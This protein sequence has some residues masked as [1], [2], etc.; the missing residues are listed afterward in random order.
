MV[1]R[2]WTAGAQLL[3]VAC[4]LLGLT[5]C[6]AQ[7]AMMKGKRLENQGDMAGAYEAYSKAYDSKPDHEEAEAGVERTRARVVSDSLEQARQ[8]L[9]AADYE[10]SVEA[11]AYAERFDND[12]P[13][14]YQ[15][16]SEVEASL[17]D[18]LIRNWESGDARATYALAVRG[19]KLF[20]K[21]EYVSATFEQVRMH[22]TTAAE[23]MLRQ[24]KFDVSL[25]AVRTITE[26]EPERTAEM[27]PLEKRILEA[28]ADDVVGEAAGHLRR[29][30]I[31]AAAA[32]YA[33][34]YELAGRQGDLDKAHELSAKLG[35]QAKLTLRLDVSGLAW[36][37]EQLGAQLSAG[38]GGIADVSVVA[39]PAR[40][41][42]R[43]TAPAPKCTE[44]D[45]V[46]P[47]SKEYVS[48]QVEKPNPDFVALAEDL[49]RGMA[50]EKAAKGEGDRL[51]PELKAAEGTLSRYDAAVDVAE[52]AHGEAEAAYDQA[53]NQLK[54]AKSKRDE[55]DAQIAAAE[56]AGTD[57]ATL[58][59]MDSELGQLGLRVSEWSGEVIKREEAE[60]RAR[61][62]LA[63][64]TAERAPAAE[65]H[66]RLKAAWD[67][68]DARKKAA[69]E[70]VGGITAKMTSTPKTVMEDVIATFDYDVHD[71]KRTCTAPVS[72][73]ATVRWSTDQPTTQSY[74]PTGETADRSHAGH[75]KAGVPVDPKE[76]PVSD[77]DLVA[78]RDAETAQELVKWTSALVADYY[79][80]QVASAR[81]ASSSDPAGASS[82]LV[83]LYVAARGRLDT[84]TQAAFQA[85]L[86][87]AFGLEQMAFLL[88]GT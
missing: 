39:V 49:K 24:D 8:K 62:G 46:T 77:A 17:R 35:E 55:L 59:R 66:Q 42:V 38:V 9:Q 63:K 37:A 43:V 7:L 71:W 19:R 10:G 58:E 41:Q 6:T 64:A 44:S 22:F 29:K 26:F 27:A 33:H 73:T 20:P 87:E 60:G 51:W 48:G 47:T 54:G 16:R 31:G 40:L 69:S 32:L 30:R 25:A 88:P 83:G 28:W 61:R 68:I 82:E 56:A 36:R 86:Q 12:H 79:A 72:A 67:E 1:R 80:V 21:A 45:A 13:E 53:A 65:A 5:A 81:S 23:K 74:A 11:L 70:R 57:K 50:E 4:V 52:R 15:V 78:Q 18:A 3:V 34:A 84:D 76:F 75:E 14:V 2:S 85:V